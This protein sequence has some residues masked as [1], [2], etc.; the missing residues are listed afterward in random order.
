MLV[1][2]Y[3]TR[4][5]VIPLQTT[6]ISTQWLRN[7]AVAVCVAP[8]SRPISY[9]PLTCTVLGFIE[10]PGSEGSRPLTLIS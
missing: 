5:S 10:T 3:N 9:N 1:E 7:E 6:G 4:I 2:L 8:D